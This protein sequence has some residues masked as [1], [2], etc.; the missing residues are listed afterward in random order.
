MNSHRL[1]S[2]A[3]ALLC[4]L[5]I[6][7]SRP[8]QA[9]Y[10]F[11]NFDGPGDN[12]GGTTVNGIS[13]NKVEVGFSMN[14]N[15]NVFTNFLRNPNGTFTLLNIL[16]DPAAMA[17]GVNSAKNVVGVTG[18]QAFLLQNANLTLLPAVNPGNTAS[19]VAFGINDKGVIVGQ[20]TDNA[21]DTTPG[22]VDKNG[23]FTI[24]NP[25]ISASVTNA[26]GINNAGL[27]TGFYSTDG[28]H[29]HG[30]FFDTNTDAFILPADP[31]V[32]NLFLTQF[33]GINDKNEAVGYYQTNNGSQHGFLYNLAAH[34]YT[35]LDDPQAANLNG[36]QIT[37]I[38]GIDNAG[39]LS[40]FYV[41]ANGLARGFFANTTP[42]PGAATLLL[43]SGLIGTSFLAGRRKRR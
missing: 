28:E 27:V 20:Y 39:D 31:N 2:L 41:D 19:E 35:F 3:L 12:G 18:G 38:T 4:G 36:V 32:A 17:N 24:L 8:A 16:G 21:T 40:G 22:F 13:N 30:F 34:T 10:Q 23:S 6:S 15:M 26:Q 29:Q 9:Q 25:V 11:L 5:G 7:A 42:E 14:A 43:A 1:P 33:L 37:Q